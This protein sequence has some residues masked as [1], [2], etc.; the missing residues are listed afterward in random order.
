MSDASGN[1]ERMVFI[2]DSARVTR[3]DEI[4]EIDFPPTVVDR[5]KLK[6]VKAKFAGFDRSPY[7]ASFQLTGLPL[8][9]QLVNVHLFYGSEARKDTE[10]RALEPDSRRTA[11][12]Q[13]RLWCSSGHA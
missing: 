8:S 5:I 2:Y 9:V 3:L 10:R 13:L 7:L 11:V 4:G 1:D 12:A 6:G